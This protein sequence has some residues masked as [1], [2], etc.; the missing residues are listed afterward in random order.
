MPLR[1]LFNDKFTTQTDGGVTVYYI[2]PGK[3]KVTAFKPGFRMFVGDVMRRTPLYKSQ[4]C[5]R[6]FS[7]DDFQGDNQA[8]CADARLD[9]EGFPTSSCS[10]IR[11]NV[12]YPTYVTPPFTLIIPLLLH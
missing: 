8:P 2:S 7:G 4:S 1:F 5:F 3:G 10:G 11:S 6:C 9:T 12:L